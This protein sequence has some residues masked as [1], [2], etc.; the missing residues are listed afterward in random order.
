MKH[1]KKSFYGICTRCTRQ[2]RFDCISFFGGRCYFC[3]QSVT[4]TGPTEAES[5]KFINKTWWSIKS[6]CNNPNQKSHFGKRKITE[7]E[8]KIWAKSTL[9]E[10]SLAN[11]CL[12]PTIHRYPDLNGP[13]QLGNLI[14]LDENE[15]KGWHANNIFKTK[16]EFFEAMDFRYR[17][18]WTLERLSRRYKCTIPTMSRNLKGEVKTIAAWREEYMERLYEQSIE[19]ED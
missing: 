11:P 6:R 9:I 4:F 15:N 1:K 14:W 10:F 12:K 19:D 13:Y 5:R 17:H 8:F 16:E 7:T 18:G 3:R 2:R